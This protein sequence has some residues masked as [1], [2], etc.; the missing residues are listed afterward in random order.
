MGDTKE[1]KEFKIEVNEKPVILTEEEVIGRQ[2]KQAAIA[3]HVAIQFD[4]VLS[5]ELG[6]RKSKVI[7]DNDIVDVKKHHKFLAVAPDDNS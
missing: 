3:Q 5:E 4:F 2:I 6:D 7:G 1:K